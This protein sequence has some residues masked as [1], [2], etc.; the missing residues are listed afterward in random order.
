MP[1][2]RFCR[3]KKL[4]ASVARVV[5][6]V[7]RAD[8]G[9]KRPARRPVRV[10]HERLELADSRSLA[11]HPDCSSARGQAICRRLTLVSNSV[12][13]NAEPVV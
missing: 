10:S 12:D 2:V 11:D 3:T 8:L 7:A 5:R 1:T 4:L 9:A 13:H 6:V